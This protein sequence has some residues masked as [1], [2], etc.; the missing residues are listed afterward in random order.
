[1]R[2]KHVARG[3][4]HSGRGAGPARRARNENKWRTDAWSSLGVNAFKLLIVLGA[5]HILGQM[6]LTVFE[7]RQ[8][9]VGLY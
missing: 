6:L 9:M 8:S 7:W 4:R 3:A 5:L 1:M 2:T